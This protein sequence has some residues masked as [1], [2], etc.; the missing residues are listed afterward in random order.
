MS[1]SRLL[2]RPA[3]TT[4]RLRRYANAVA[5]ADDAIDVAVEA[6][7][8]VVDAARNHG[9]TQGGVG[10]REPVRQEAVKRGRERPEFCLPL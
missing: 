1:S 4:P 9:D 10:G 3:R 6:A 7:V 5:A 2:Q 8:E